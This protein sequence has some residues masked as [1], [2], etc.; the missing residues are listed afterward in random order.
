MYVDSDK[1]DV[2]AMGII[3]FECASLSRPFE[4]G[5]QCALIMKI[6][7]AK[8]DIPAHVSPEVRDI[9]SWCVQKDAKLRPT[10]KELLNEVFPLFI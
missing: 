10:I 5:N 9:I 8:Y 2:W 3:L 7:T 6:V 1:S 4:A